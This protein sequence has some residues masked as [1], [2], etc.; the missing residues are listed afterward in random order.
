MVRE[1]ERV[2]M[3]G[4]R[5]ASQAWRPPGVSVSSSHRGTGHVQAGRD[6]LRLELIEEL[7]DQDLPPALGDPAQRAHHG[8]LPVEQRLG[9][10]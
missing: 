7:Q 1:T 9:V 5:P 8:L 4:A 2:G 10:E 3:K 6:L